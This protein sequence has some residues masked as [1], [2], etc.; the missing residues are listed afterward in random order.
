[1]LGALSSLPA[2][3][4][5]IRRFGVAVDDRGRRGAWAALAFVAAALLTGCTASTSAPSAT[6]ADASP[7][8]QNLP[9]TASMS[10]R[11]QT[12]YLSVARTE[13][14]Q[15][16]G[17]MFVRELPPDRGMLFVFDPAQPVGFWM[18]DTL[19]PLDMIFVRN[20]RIVT[21]DREV[22]PCTSD[23]CPNY[24]SGAAVDQ[25]IELAGGRARELGLQPNHQLIV[26]SG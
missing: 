24:S 14:Q 23:P 12:V 19:I 21:I 5:W 26:S 16:D 17:L 11:G 13:Q 7:T 15:S 1:M 6:S 9:P 3:L 2:T 4:T 10:A 22:P 20:G 25:V 8:P 18:K